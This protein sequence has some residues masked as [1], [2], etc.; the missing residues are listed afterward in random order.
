MLDAHYPLLVNFEQ[1]VW[2]LDHIK[3]DTF[4]REIDLN[5]E[6]RYPFYILQE[7]GIPNDVLIYKYIHK[8]Y[9]KF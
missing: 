7:L 5:F 6:G 4:L 8:N 2:N 1:K 3:H 9:D